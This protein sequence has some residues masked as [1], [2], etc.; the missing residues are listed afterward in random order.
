[1]QTAV[2]EKYCRIAIYRYDYF[3]VDPNGSGIKKEVY[4]RPYSGLNDLN[5]IKRHLVTKTYDTMYDY[6]H[7]GIYDPIRLKLNI[8]YVI[9]RSSIS[10]N[11]KAIFNMVAGIVYIYD[12]QNI[13]YKG[14][15]IFIDNCNHCIS[16]FDG[17]N[18]IRDI[19]IDNP[20][21]ISPCLEKAYEF[22]DDYIIN[23]KYKIGSDNSSQI[24]INGFRETK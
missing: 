19:K 6:I 17:S 21:T 14:Y 2:I 10:Y 1:M 20:G 24:A 18:K 13:K 3:G 12:S 22:I 8:L 23:N 11:R 15:P 5:K 7:S 9:T 4:R 16:V